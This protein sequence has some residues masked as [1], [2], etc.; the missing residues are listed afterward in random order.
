MRPAMPWFERIF[1]WLLALQHDVY[2]A[3]GANIRGMGE[4]A[5]DTAAALAFGLALGAIHALTPG[6][7]KAVVFSYFLG[8][9]ARPAAGLLMAAKIAGTHVASALALVAVFGSAASMFGRAS[10]TAMNIQIASYSLIVA[11]G[12]WLLFRALAGLRESRAEVSHSHGLSSGILPFAIGLLPCPM[13]MLIMT[14]ALAHATLMA[15]LV[16][17]LV[18]A[19]GIAATIALVGTGGLLVRR[20]LFAAVDPE[21]RR[22]VRA[23]GILEALSSVAIVVIGAAFL[24]AS[25]R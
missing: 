21:G 1:A 2:V 11:A 3:L 25:V 12:L 7:G 5:A 8:T 22:Y 24:L 6:H 20:G 16:L 17:T 23:I 13:T 18:L 15:G 14:Y 4:T 9:Q 10:G 19:L